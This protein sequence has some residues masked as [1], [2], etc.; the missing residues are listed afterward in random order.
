MDIL[1]EIRKKVS[2]GIEQ[3]R[4]AIAAITLTDTPGLIQ[5]AVQGQ[6][7]ALAELRQR[8][9]EDPETTATVI[10]KIITPMV[11]AVAPKRKATGAEIMAAVDATDEFD[12]VTARR[13]LRAAFRQQHQ[14]QPPKPAA[15]DTRPILKL[16][17]GQPVRIHAATLAEIGVPL[18]MVNVAEEWDDPDD[19][20]ATIQAPP[21]YRP[22]YVAIG[23]GKDKRRPIMQAVYDLPAFPFGVSPVTDRCRTFAI[24]GDSG[25]LVD[26]G[27]VNP[28]AM[29]V[30]YTHG[31]DDPAGTMWHPKPHIQYDDLKWNPMFAAW[32]AHKLATNTEISRRIDYLAVETMK[33]ETITIITH[34]YSNHGQ[35][36]VEEILR[37]ARAGV[38]V[39]L[40][41]KRAGYTG[42]LPGISPVHYT[43][44]RPTKPEPGVKTAGRWFDWRNM[45]K[46][47]DVH[48]PL[49]RV[50]ESAKYV[51]CV[52]GEGKLVEAAPD[53]VALAHGR[54][55]RQF[56]TDGAEFEALIWKRPANADA[57]RA[58]F[59]PALDGWFGYEPDY[60][61]DDGWD[62]GEFIE[63]EAEKEAMD[64]ALVHG[65][66]QV[67]DLIRQGFDAEAAAE[68]AEFDKGLPRKRSQKAEALDTILAKTYASQEAAI[69][70]RHDAERNM[71]WNDFWNGEIGEAD[72]ERYAANQGYRDIRI[73]VSSDLCTNEAVREELRRT[74]ADTLVRMHSA[75]AQLMGLPPVIVEINGVAL[76]EE[77]Q[78]EVNGG[79]RYLPPLTPPAAAQPAAK[80]SKQPK[81]A[82]KGT[83]KAVQIDRTQPWAPKR[84]TGKGKGKG[85]K[86]TPKWPQPQPANKPATSKPFANYWADLAAGRI[87][88][89]VEVA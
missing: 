76:T 33:G 53:K 2:D 80:P 82:K 60:D 85:R 61:P 66:D 73:T 31:K 88:V 23:S 4:D 34:E 37:R 41:D 84:R 77:Q 15:P 1:Q 28:F 58:V 49:Y 25:E 7:D 17:Q 83:K 32:L 52:T 72:L 22:A 78:L 79:R 11:E 26:L 42:A 89:P 3:L 68:I 12:G 87:P 59:Q 9:Q 74:N 71:L 16:T 55:E 19:E 14:P 36:I 39:A 21:D 29:P 48:T 35:Q 30:H 10:L 56:T 75:V 38:R 86:F 5:E 63:S 50:E 54:W 69:T 70:Y 27:I 81:K 51:L 65:D 47:E 46:V 62:D 57:L 8:W 20:D 67:H 40:A 44:Q 64:T 6:E 13:M 18:R 45:V 24:F 43:D